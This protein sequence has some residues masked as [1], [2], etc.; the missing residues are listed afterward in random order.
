MQQPLNHFS[1]TRARCASQRSRGGVGLHGIDIGA[2]INAHLCY[3]DLTLRGAAVKQV[4]SDNVA[5]L[6]AYNGKG[7]QIVTAIDVNGNWTID[8]SGADR[9]TRTSKEVTTHGA[10]TV[11]RTT[12]EVWEADGEN[13]PVTQS[14]SDVTPDGLYSWQTVCGLTTATVTTATKQ[15]RR[16]IATQRLAPPPVPDATTNPASN[17]PPPH[18]RRTAPRAR[19]TADQRSRD[20]I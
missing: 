3:L 2:E 18:V 12:T 6:F 16:R 19:S 10:H 5:T 13:T 4:D 17:F 9:I 7:E 15:D 8:Y 20:K 11:Q 1:F 14:V